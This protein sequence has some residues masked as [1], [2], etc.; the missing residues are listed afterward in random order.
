MPVWFSE[1]CL[2]P[3]VLQSLKL[4]VFTHFFM[5]WDLRSTDFNYHEAPFFSQRLS[6]IRIE[7]H[8]FTVPS[9]QPL[10]CSPLPSWQSLFISS[11]VT[12][13]CSQIHK[14]DMLSLFLLQ[15]LSFFIYIIPLLSHHI[16]TWRWKVLVFT[17]LLLLCDGLFP[18]CNSNL[19]LSSSVA[20]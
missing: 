16:H 7:L 2:K 11:I 3:G 13:V 14:Y 1:L 20:I 4:N 18:P 17:H 8:H 6:L 9:P 5:L 12:C 15:P 19:F 10:L